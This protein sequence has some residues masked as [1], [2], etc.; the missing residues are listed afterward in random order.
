VEYLPFGEVWIEETDPAT[1]Y[2]P[3]RFTSKELDEETGLY[4][5]GARYYEPTISRWMSADPA[6]FA[7]SSPM[8]S[9]GKPK[10]GYSIIEAVNWYAYVSNNP[11][12][13]VDPT[14]ELSFS[15][16]LGAG[17]AVMIEIETGKGRL[18]TRIS[19]GAG[20]G[21]FAS[22]DS[23][24]ADES[25]LEGAAISTGMRIKAEG[26][27]GQASIGFEGISE[28]EVDFQGNV[29][30]TN[31]LE[32]GVSNL[33]GQQGGV[34][35]DAEEGKYLKEPQSSSMGIGKMVFGGFSFGFSSDGGLDI[36]R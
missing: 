15:A 32:L 14:G 9:D 26:E 11:V 27:L 2:I 1:G 12:I 10:T 20:T 19:I 36:E 28:T 22:I 21:A 30:V 13:Y 29:E 17:V 25:K 8:G 33:E 35:F 16:G 24:E 31:R 6:G 23:S 34:I 4:Y 5:H 3:F 18:K 7:L